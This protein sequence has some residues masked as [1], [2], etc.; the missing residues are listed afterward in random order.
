MTVNFYL[1]GKTATDAYKIFAFGDDGY[2]ELLNPAIQNIYGVTDLAWPSA[3]RSGQNVTVFAS[4][5]DGAKWSRIMRFLSTDG[6]LTFNAGTTVFI[7]NSSEPQGVGPAAIM[8]DASLASPYVMYYCLRGTA[9]VACADSPDG[10]TW[11]RRG[12][13]YTGTGSDEIGTVSVSYA[14]KHDGQYVVGIHC[15]NSALTIAN[16]KIITSTL[17]TSGF[18]ASTLLFSPDNFAS[19]ATTTVGGSWATVPAGV[20]VP[21]GIPLVFA[22]TTQE[23][24]V[25]RKQLGTAV[26]FEWPFSVARTNINFASAARVKAD[27]SHIWQKPD[28]TWEGYLTGY[29]AFDAAEFCTSIISPS[30]T[31][32]WTYKRDGLPFRC[33]YSRIESMENPT[34]VVEL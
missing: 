15:Y 10:I 21:L 13:I 17:P 12:V 4:A 22:G 25:A 33:W 19:T 11:T 32:P 1:N 2:P 9:N 24:N 16:S 8:Y 27:I 18:G 3:F 31:G 34:P 7:S 6:G 5:Y 20:T 28:G 23:V 30:M 14:F 26:W 29:G